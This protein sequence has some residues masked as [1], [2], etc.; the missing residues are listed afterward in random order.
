MH[1]MWIQTMNDPGA[2]AKFNDAFFFVLVY[3]AGCPPY[4]KYVTERTNK[5]A[6]DA[7]L[8]VLREKFETLVL[9][10]A[11]GGKRAEN[12]GAKEFQGSIDFAMAMR[13]L[14]LRC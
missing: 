10:R 11:A 9:G 7:F 4:T 8:P 1:E 5:K 2:M 3:L 12:P 6:M 13:S 14:F